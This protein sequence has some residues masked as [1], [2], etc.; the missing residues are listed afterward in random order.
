MYVCTPSHA[1]VSA[2]RAVGVCVCA[3]CAAVIS[4][5][6]TGQAI[7][8]RKVRDSR[9][10]P[11]R[12]FGNDTRTVSLRAPLTF[13]YRELNLLRLQE[14]KEKKGKKKCEAKQLR[15]DQARRISSAPKMFL[16]SN[17]KNTIVLPVASVNHD[18]NS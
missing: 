8:K 9:S 2:C 17:N 13:A 5:R 14:K 15:R 12:V 16:F 1:R 10:L 4:T 6:E 7:A 3:T 18:R 11:E